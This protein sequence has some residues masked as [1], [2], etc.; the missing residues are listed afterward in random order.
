LPE[1]DELGAS[2]LA[3]RLRAAV[4]GLSIGCDGER[5]SGTVSIG[6]AAAQAG[7]ET[8]RKGLIAAADAALYE[9]RREGRNRIG[10]GGEA[11]V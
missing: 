7:E 11:L 5:L 1:L 2:A 3:E 4:A 10:V 8:T 6:V 9:A